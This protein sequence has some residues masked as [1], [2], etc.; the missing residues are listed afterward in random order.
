MGLFSRRSASHAAARDAVPA[1]ESFWTWWTTTGATETD[2]AILGGRTDD[3]VERLGELV[4]AMDDRLNW[5]LSAGTTSRHVL[6][7]TADQKP[8]VAAVAR[9]WLRHAPAPDDVWQYADTRLAAAHLAD[10]ELQFTGAAVPAAEVVLDVRAR[11]TALD[12]GLHHPALAALPRDARTRAMLLLLDQALGEADVELW[13]GTM[14]VLDAA[15]ATPVPLTELPARVRSLRAE[16]VSDDS[17]VGWALASG[18]DRKGRPFVATVS[19][20]LRSAVAP[21]LDTHVEVTVPYTDRTDVGMPRTETLQRLRGLEDHLV[22]RLGDSG[23]LVAHRTGDGV[24]TL[25]LYV[26]GTTP[27]ADQL[28]AATG[29]WEQGRVTVTARHDPSWEQV[30][31]LRL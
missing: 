4:A 12:V 31:P 28:R 30:A 18:R 10:V 20:P 1:I 21:Q 27:A 7:V 29:G 23:R 11:R 16:W 2:A 24:R 9:R 5:E 3:V 19:V 14:E 22:D 8:V 13:I 6:V 17:D 15:P 25:H 26:D